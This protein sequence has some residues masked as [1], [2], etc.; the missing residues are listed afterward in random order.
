[1]GGEVLERVSAVPAGQLG[2][3]GQEK[4]AGATR[5]M[6]MWVLVFETPE[7][8]VWVDHDGTRRFL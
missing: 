2:A 7:G 4:G 5:K 1:V 3:P 6:M 8:E